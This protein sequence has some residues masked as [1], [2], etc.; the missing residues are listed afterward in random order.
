MKTRSLVA[1]IA[2]GFM[3]LSPISQAC[4]AVDVQAKD[5]SVIAGRTMEWFYDMQWQVASL[6]IGTDYQMTAPPKLGLPAVP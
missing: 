2:S 1:A 3:T 5:G 6:P 4:T